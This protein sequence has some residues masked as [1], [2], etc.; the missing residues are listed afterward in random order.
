[1][2]LL[3]S[4]SVAV[5]NQL[6]VAGQ[7]AGRVN[8]HHGP[9]TSVS[10]QAPPVRRKARHRYWHSHEGCPLRFQDARTAGCPRQMNR[11]DKTVVL[12]SIST[13]ADLPFS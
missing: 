5:S 9:P 3:G 4:V 8:D 1:M 7:K 12:E 13:V 6:Y 2:P 10:L 11:G